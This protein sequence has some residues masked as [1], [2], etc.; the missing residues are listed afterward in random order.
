MAYREGY[1]DRWIAEVDVPATAVSLRVG[2]LAREWRDSA[3]GR[4]WYRKRAEQT[5]ERTGPHMVDDRG[6]RAGV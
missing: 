3:A 1:I 6:R 4:E 2:R 5:W